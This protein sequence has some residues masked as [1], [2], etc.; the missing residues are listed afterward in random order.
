MFVLYLLISYLEVKIEM[1]THLANRS[2]IHINNKA[3]VSKQNMYCNK[4]IND[5]HLTRQEF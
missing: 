5:I 2:Y 3:Q 4:M 1:H